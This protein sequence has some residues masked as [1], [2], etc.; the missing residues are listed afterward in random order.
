VIDRQVPIADVQR[1]IHHQRS[2]LL[3]DTTVV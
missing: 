2:V 3:Q 1:P